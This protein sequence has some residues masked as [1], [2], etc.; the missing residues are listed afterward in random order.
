VRGVE[1]IESEIPSLQVK[2]KAVYSGGLMVT[3]RLV[4]TVVGFVSTIILARLLT[5]RDFGL[6]AMVTVFSLL[7]F[8][9]GLN[10][11]LESI[12]QSKKI[13]HDQISTLFWIG[14]AIS[15]SL[16][17]IFV[18]A[19]P[20]LALLYK[21]PKVIPIS[22]VMAIGFIF[23]ALATEHLALIMRKLQFYKIMIN[24]LV[25]GVISTFIAIAMALL[26]F[27]YWA[28]VA[29][30]LSVPIIVA[31]LSWI[32]CSW[33]PGLPKKKA[34]IR[35]MLKFAINTF[36]NFSINYFA[37]NIDKTILGWKWGSF[38]LG[39]YDRAYRLFVLP[40]N[41]LIDP[42]SS[43]ALSALSKIKD[44]T[45]MYKKYY[46]RSLSL[47]GFLGMY[48]SSILTISGREII[49]LLL[50]PK[51]NQAGI[52]FTAFGPAVAVILIYQTIGWLFLSQGRPDALLKW[53]I[54][55][56]LLMTASYLFGVRFGAIGMALAY[57]IS[58]YILIIPGLYFAG[59]YAGIGLKDIWYIIWR[60]IFTAII[61][62][63]AA[64]ISISLIISPLGQVSSFL[65]LVLKLFII[66]I[67]YLVIILV[68]FRQE[69][70]VYDFVN[71]IRIMLKKK[72]NGDK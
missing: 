48:I 24:E 19:S 52:V 53:T 57:G 36:G 9:V 39:N 22:R 34:G 14:L 60:Y 47:I 54:A 64:I 41:Q 10:G 58:L 30:Q 50:G 38:Q 56:T 1:Y 51:W 49:Y 7:L 3:T 63:L 65:R 45:E 66:T 69:Q 12:I 21:E 40:V 5:P 43:V 18:F 32:Q 23:S 6:V 68:I 31:I 42:L 25:S 11:F 33:R 28:I 8:N 29:R 15:S 26:G 55:A 13:N 17:L 37:R 20:L 72:D 4:G 35:P 27:G 70:Q 44:N 61:S 67:T 59:R 62:S 2:D 71:I 16:S 46:L